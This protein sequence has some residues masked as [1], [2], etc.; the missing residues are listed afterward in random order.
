MVGA[1]IYNISRITGKYKHEI[2]KISRIANNVGDFVFQF[3][4]FAMQFQLKLWN[5]CHI[6][7]TYTHK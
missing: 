2:S 5:K 3:I 1:V 4:E 7:Y 6:I